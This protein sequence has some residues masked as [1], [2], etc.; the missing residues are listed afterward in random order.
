MQE[1]L[2]PWEK[3]E[4]WFYPVPVSKFMV[5][6]FFTLNL[7]TYYW[8]YQNWK[9]I[10]VRTGR[11]LSPFWRTFFALFYFHA[12]GKEF[13]TDAA[14][15]EVESDLNLPALTVAFVLLSFAWQLPGIA[16]FL[17]LLTF[18]PLVPLQRLANRIHVVAAPEVDRNEGYSVAN[19]IGILVGGLLLML[20][21]A[22]ELLP[23]P[24]H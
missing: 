9:L 15:A 21:I 22:G 16:G 4:P 12:L 1:E 8:I 11:D 18:W 2:S 3:P 6:S 20:A 17:G 19:A 24:L 7:Y 14:R 13:E 10:R 23:D 5:M